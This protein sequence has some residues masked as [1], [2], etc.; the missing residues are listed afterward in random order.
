VARA[1]WMT[2]GWSHRV[3]RIPGCWARMAASRLPCPPATSTSVLRPEQPEDTEV[4]QPRI[5]IRYTL[6]KSGRA[7]TQFDFDV[8]LRRPGAPPVRIRYQVTP[9]K[10]DLPVSGTGTAPSDSA[11]HDDMAEH[12]FEKLN[13]KLGSVFFCPDSRAFQALHP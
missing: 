13:Q 5:D 1:A 3:L 12:A 9:P 6:S 2:E 7:S 11:V 10:D 4:K 8:A